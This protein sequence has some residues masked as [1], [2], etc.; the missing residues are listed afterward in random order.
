MTVILDSSLFPDIRAVLG[1]TSDELSD[2]ELNTTGITAFTN[3]QLGVLIPD[4][5]VLTGDDIV[6]AKTAGIYMAAALCTGILR[7]KRAQQIKIGDYEESN[8]RNTDFDKWRDWL[9]SV[10]SDAITGLTLFDNIFVKP[11]LFSVGGP[12]SSGKNY[13]TNMTKWYTR[14][15]PM[16]NN[17]FTLG[18]PYNSEFID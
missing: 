5:S 2:A 14:V 13:P 11:S 3:A 4:F 16:I 10:A 12:T 1:T 7:I 15:S 18:T 8:A 17:W 9:L 6:Y